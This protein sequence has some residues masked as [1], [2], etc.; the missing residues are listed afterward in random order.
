MM[1][2]VARLVMSPL[3]FMQLIRGLRTNLE[4]YEKTFGKLSARPPVPQPSG[5]AEG[6]PPAPAD[7]PPGATDPQDT[8]A[9]AGQPAVAGGGAAAGGGSGEAPVAEQSQ[10]PSEPGQ[11]AQAP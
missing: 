2:W 1:R 4:K 7:A 8:G 11:P 3:T 6:S 10:V 5:P 9:V